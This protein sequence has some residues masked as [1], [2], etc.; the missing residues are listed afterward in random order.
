MIVEKSGITGA[1]RCQCAVIGRARRNE[2]RAAIPALYRDASF[3]N[4][5][6]PPG[7]AFGRE[8]LAL[9]MTQ[10]RAYTKKFPTCEPPGLLLIG[11]P[12][13]GK[14]HLAV[15]ALRSL[16]GQGFE[17][18]FY[19]YQNLLQRIRSSYDAASGTADRE[20]YRSALEA[21]ILL[22]DDL[23]AHR[24]TDWVEDTITSIITFRCNNKKP[25]IVTTNL[26]DPD[27]GMAVVERSQMVPGKTEYRITLQEKIGIR[28]RSRLFE[29]CKVIKM[30]GVE[31]YR[32]RRQR[33]GFGTA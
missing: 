12:G 9:V 14:T 30:P 24:V 4:F 8:D 19:D 32:V 17:G 13:T 28:A 16:I 6:L 1:E 3:E 31:D 15:A 25:V 33:A 20:A 29:M 18:L 7:N 21:E 22:L 26:P 23:G 27:A 11:D 2:D 10:V 5:V